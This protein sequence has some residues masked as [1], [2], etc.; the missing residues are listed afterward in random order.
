MLSVLQYYWFS[1]KDSGWKQF[2]YSQGKILPVGF[3]VGSFYN[4]FFVSIVLDIASGI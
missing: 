4:F 1:H 3:F 2:L